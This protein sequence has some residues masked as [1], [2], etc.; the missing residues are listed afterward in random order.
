MATSDVEIVRLA[1]DAFMRGDLESALGFCDP[2]IVVHDPGR[3]GATIHGR[4]GLMQFWEEWLENWETYR[5]E[6]EEFIEAGGEIFVACC[7]RGRGR[8]SGIEVGQDLFQVFRLREGKIVQYRIYADRATA[9][10]SV[11]LAA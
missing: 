7:Q 4:A 8:L 11:G 10:E 5:V 3:T 2:E 6:A 1:F 9:L